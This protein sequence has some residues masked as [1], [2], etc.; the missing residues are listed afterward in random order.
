MTEEPFGKE[1]DRI[2][3]AVID[4]LDQLIIDWRNDGRPNDQK[5][6]TLDVKTKLCELGREH[7][8][9]TGAA[10]VA[11]KSRDFGEWLYDVTWL[12]YA[13]NGGGMIG[14]PLILETEN[15]H[16]DQEIS[17][18]WEKLIV[19]NAGHRVMMFGKR[20]DAEIEEKFEEM[21]SE[22]DRYE[23]R[24][25]GDRYLLAGFSDESEVFHYTVHQVE[26]ST[27]RGRGK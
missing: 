27:W 14:C 2:E 7:H 15:D 1:P 23:E 8:C 17:N 13:P 21:I 25:P 6:W 20:T 24:H 19:A 18:D 16:R 3:Q 26:I 12:R 5:K 11:E 22:A 4:T 10:H 9:Q